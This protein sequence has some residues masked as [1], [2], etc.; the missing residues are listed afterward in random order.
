MRRARTLRRLVIGYAF[1]A[2]LWVAVADR[3]VAQAP[4]P[5]SSSSGQSGKD[6]P[7]LPWQYGALFTGFW[8]CTFAAVAIVSKSSNRSDKP[9]KRVI[10]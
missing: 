6:K 2:C 1:A 5:P 3:A 9:V 7:G 4:A 8:V 10:E